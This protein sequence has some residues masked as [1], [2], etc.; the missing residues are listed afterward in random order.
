MIVHLFARN[1]KVRDCLELFFEIET[2]T[3][4]IKRFAVTSQ[5]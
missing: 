3:F 2:D 5:I 4:R 1:Y